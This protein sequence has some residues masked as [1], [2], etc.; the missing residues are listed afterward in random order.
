MAH[1]PA[2]SG[3]QGGHGVCRTVSPYRAD[4]LLQVMA[5]SPAPSG[6]QGGHG[7][8]RIVSALP[9]GRTLRHLRFR[10]KNREGQ[11]AQTLE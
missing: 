8:C 5:H 11:F 10:M 9:A 6:I 2:P 1:S 4:P 7:V 3:V